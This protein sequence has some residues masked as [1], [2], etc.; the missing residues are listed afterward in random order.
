MKVLHMCN[1]HKHIDRP[2][3]TSLAALLTHMRTG[4]MHLVV[5]AWGGGGEGCAVCG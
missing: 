3:Q 1:Y 4:I 2:A 5:W